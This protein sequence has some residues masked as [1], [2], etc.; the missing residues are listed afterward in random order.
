MTN[1]INWFEKTSQRKILV[2]LF[3]A[4][5]L[6][7]AILLL[8]F[9]IVTTGEATK[10][11]DECHLL[12]QQGNFSENKY[13]FYSV[14]IFIHIV[15]YKLGFETIGVYMFQLLLNLLAAYFFHQLIVKIRGKKIIAFI[16]VLLLFMTQ[17]FQM[18]T[19]HLYTES[20]YSSLIIIFSYCF[21]TRENKST[22]QW[23]LTAFIFLL[24]LFARPT[25]LLMI[26]VMMI[27][28][29]FRLLH[30]K[31][32]VI[33]ISLTAIAAA[34]FY[35]LL[36]YAMHSSNSFDFLKPFAENEVLCYIPA[37]NTAPLT[38]HTG[39][40]SLQD[41]IQYITHNPSQFLYLSWQK[42]ISYWGM[43][44]YYDSPLHNLYFVLFF[45][46]LYLLAVIGLVKI[47]KQQKS[48]CVFCIA[49]FFIFTLSVILT[50]DD[51]NNR[52]NIPVIPFVMLLAA[53]GIHYL[54]ELWN[55]RKIKII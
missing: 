49:M 8:S 25:G 31:K 18:W 20:V 15:F 50:C 55:S 39:S 36:D 21:F 1:I 29:F 22:K 5:L 2:I 37:E 33:A 30:Q 51:W 41:I 19:V 44:R 10:Y 17:T 26:P 47:Y 16:A 52:F 48:F 12:L 13:I 40:N 14:Y 45:Y 11:F 23:I 24:I 3:F 35:F 46:P 4:W 28:F 7:Q 38:T 9:G 6:L 53:V 27:Y 32:Y 34:A 42:F 54:Y 43:Q